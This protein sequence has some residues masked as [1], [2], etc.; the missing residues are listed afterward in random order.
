[1]IPFR[2]F[3]LVKPLTA[4]LSAVLE[5][6]HQDDKDH[7]NLEGRGIVEKVGPGLKT[8]RKYQRKGF[9]GPLEISEGDLVAYEGH[10]AYPNVHGQLIMQA[11]DVIVLEFEEGESLAD[12]MKRENL[13]FDGRAVGSRV[14]LRSGVTTHV[15]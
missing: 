5:V 15:S 9:Y 8:G 6:I 11:A 7:P 1:M 14:G 13:R 12:Y 3:L 4:A 2:D 10:K